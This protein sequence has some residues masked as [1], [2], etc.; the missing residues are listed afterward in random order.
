MFI[1]GV[2]VPMKLVTPSVLFIS[3][4]PFISV[5]LTSFAFFVSKVNFSKSEGF[6]TP[7]HRQSTRCGTPESISFGRLNFIVS[8][9]TSAKL[10]EQKLKKL[11]S[12]YW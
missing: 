10:I 7:L 2:K 4:D 9:R 6:T 1:E 3:R 8:V 11:V 12:I 5:K